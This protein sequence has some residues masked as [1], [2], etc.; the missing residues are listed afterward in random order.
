M[1]KIFLGFF[2]IGLVSFGGG[3]AMIPLLERLI[4]T[5]KWMTLSDFA[6]IIGIAEMTPGPIAVN[7]AT[8]IGYKTN[9]LFGGL[10]ATTGVALPSLIIILLISKI[11]FNKKYADAQKVL[12]YG[13]RPVIVGLI[14]AAAFSVAKT[15][16]FNGNISISNLNFW[17][18]G[19]CIFIVIAS[20]KTKIHPILLLVISGCM[21]AGLYI[22][23]IV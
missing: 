5:N 10:I 1:L 4:A 2:E 20:L 11:L 9:G 14:V 13:M 15:C 17:S 16:F 21:G 8:F 22:L 7:S 6:N 18:I 3:Y 19:I 23:G 12:F